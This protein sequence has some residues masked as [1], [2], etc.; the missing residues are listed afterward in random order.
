MATKVINSLIIPRKDTYANWTASTAGILQA[1]EFGLD[2][3]NNILKC[4]DGTN[5]WADLP[6][7]NETTLS[8]L[9]ITAT[10]TE[11]NYVDGVTSSIQTQLN[12]KAPKASPTFT[13]TATFNNLNSKTIGLGLPGGSGPTA[14]YTAFSVGSSTTGYVPTAN[15][16]KSTSDSDYYTLTFPSKTGTI[17]VTSDMPTKTSQLTNDSGFITSYTDTK[18]T[19]GSTNTS[20]KI[21][22]IGATSQAA[23][24]QTY[25]H[26]TAYVGTDGCLYSGSKKVSVE[27]HTH[28]YLPTSGGSAT[29]TISA[30]QLSGT[31]VRIG[32]NS[33]S[34]APNVDGATYINIGDSDNSYTPRIN[35]YNADATEK[36]AYAFPASSGT[37]SINSHTHTVKSPTATVTGA[38]YT[39]AGT[40]SKI[41]PA[42][43]IST[44]TGTANYTPAGTVSAPT[45]TVTP[46]TTSVYSITGVGTAPSLSTTTYTPL[47]TATLTAGTTPPSISVAD[48]TLVVATGTAPSLSTT[49]TSIKGVNTWSAGSVPTR[50]SVTVVNSIKS[51]TSTAPSFTGTGT[52]LLFTGTAVTPTFS[53][54][55]ATIKPSVS[56]ST[57]TTEAA[58]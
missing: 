9:G 48:G 22:L 39:P 56:I 55:A 7:L 4:G 15:V 12:N 43:T 54:T 13:G 20:S 45:I 41:T 40:V 16:Y 26:D 57:T 31:N 18:N 3:T 23:N 14:G 50:S 49:T 37:L 24:P 27:G 25:S 11:L 19:S 29:G 34:S 28:S 6:E 10:A 2:T 46:N 36:Y 1:G 53:G 21:F 58:S 51:A 44:G 38:S 32:M 47:A 30:P 17:A 33:T 35:V 52:Q 42:G 8:D 5:R